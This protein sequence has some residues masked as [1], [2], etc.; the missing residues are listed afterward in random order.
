L[1]AQAVLVSQP[2]LV[3]LA[4]VLVSQARL[5]S[6][7]PVLV[8]QAPVLVSQAPVLV[9]Q[10]PVLVSQAPVLVAQSGRCRLWHFR[11]F[12]HLQSHWHQYR[13]QLADFRLPG[14]RLKG[15]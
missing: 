14:A 15:F 2:R 8:S 3:A 9:S 10:A 6:Q 12:Y 4:P 5:V 13:Y 11:Y 1:V 7:A